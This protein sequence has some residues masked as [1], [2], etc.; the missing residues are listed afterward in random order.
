[1]AGLR[2]R[3]Q[4]ASKSISNRFADLTQS[5]SDLFSR[6][7]SMFKNY[8]LFKEIKNSP[9]NKTQGAIKAYNWYKEYRRDKN[10]WLKGQLMHQG[11]L[12]M[13]DYRTPKYK[14]TPQ[15]PWF[16]ENP[17][18]ICLGHVKTSL[19]WRTININMHILPPVT[20][21]I[22]MS[23]IFDFNKNK[24]KSMLGKKEQKDVT[25]VSYKKLIKP[26]EQY[27]VGFAIRMY[28]PKLQKNIVEFRFDDWKNAI[29]LES[30]KLNGITVVELAKA[31]SDYVEEHN[32]KNEKKLNKSWLK[33]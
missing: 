24:Y 7:T 4:A 10:N 26:L 27:G 6:F 29:F 21:R 23:K 14:D 11:R 15:L 9:W 33:S 18:V 25:S 32:K 30:R 12:Y 13:F 22:V 5:V 19:G 2:Q 20:R 31:W 17:L 28:I 3:V 8:D 1:M 16:D